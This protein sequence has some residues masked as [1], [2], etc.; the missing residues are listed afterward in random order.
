MDASIVVS[1]ALKP[2]SVPD[3]AIVQAAYSRG[4]ALSF[5]VFG[6]IETVLARPKFAKSVLPENRAK[7]LARILDGAAWFEP[8]MRVAEC[9]DPKDD[10]YLE[11][12][13]AASA[14]AIVTGDADLLDMDPWRGVR[15][16]RPA[17]YLAYVP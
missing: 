5:A 13:L 4:V 12:A 11:L 9:R 3:T 2:G 15:L 6:E 10:K 17:E 1:A 7:L 8:S 16:L 14:S